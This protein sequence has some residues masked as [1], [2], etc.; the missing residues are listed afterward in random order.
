MKNFGRLFKTLLAVAMLFISGAAVYA[1]EPQGM[2]DSLNA[3]KI[4]ARRPFGS[5]IREVS[6]KKIRSVVSPLGTGDV[7]KFVQTLPGVSF[8]MEGTSA[9]YVRGG[10]N[11]NNLISL[12]GVT[13]YGTSHLMGLL[14]LIPDEIIAK[15]EFIVGGFD[16]WDG[17]LLSSHIK[18]TSHGIKDG[19]FG[20]IVVS[21]MNESLMFSLPAGKHFYFLGAA[22]V[23][24]AQYEY[25]VIAKDIISDKLN[26]P[27]KIKAQVYDYYGKASYIPYNR[28][29][30]NFSYLSSYD[31]YNWDTRDESSHDE[32]GWQNKIFIADA[33][34]TP[35]DKLNLYLSYSDN[36][37][38]S[39]QLQKRSVNEKNS[40]LMH[41]FSGISEK[42]TQV[43][44]SFEP[45][46]TI[47]IV[48]GAD[49]KKASFTPAAF[50]ARKRAPW[51]TDTLK[52][53]TSIYYA[54]AEIGNPDEACI[55]LA[56][57]FN[58][59][60]GHD[61]IT[62]KVPEF[63]VKGN[64]AVSEH[65]GIELT[66][67]RLA[68][69]YH[70]LEGVPTGFSIDLIV[71]SRDSL[72][73]EKADQFY[74]GIVSRGELPVNFSIGAF[75]KKMSGLVFF[76]KADKFFTTSAMEWE[77]NLLIGD[78][79]SRGLEVSLDGNYKKFSGRLAYTLSKT[80][81]TFDKLNEGKPFPF[82]FDR[83]HIL[84]LSGKYLIKDNERVTHALNGLFTYTSGHKESLRAG[85]YPVW[86]DPYD[87]F[88]W[89]GQN[90][91]LDYFT[92]PNN[93][94]MKPYIRLDISYSLTLKRKSVD[95]EFVLG[96]YN[97][98]NRHNPYALT[99]DM[100][101]ERWMKISIFPIM[102][103]ICYRMTF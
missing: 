24:P 50:A 91:D 34:W 71:P 81:R 7:I 45:S 35:I 63:R 96:I 92:H 64:L 22:R 18:M 52:A 5:S 15:N 67:D 10:N 102:P 33:D 19:G 2:V 40:T 89:K 94:T 17:N 20:S 93:Y 74:A 39:D 16:A 11:G 90:F 78:G 76:E 95:H 86:A 23:S 79:S 49:F 77:E 14:A 58:L 61:G 51:L 6:S 57:R 53:R 97:V 66:Y 37:F 68:Q 8:G 36:Y 69:F 28:L 29:T 4:T 100:E 98:F 12:D 38:H 1:Q 25:N 26:L 27:N 13:I 87:F 54:Q 3:S 43:R 80:D 62:K 32:M 44:I 30:F 56:S 9:F 31:A 85:T 21:N 84:S 46:E 60:K 48:A 59:Y 75:W 55:K 88:K 73:Y 82:K 42:K 83:R 65:L 103:S 101:S 47:K 41:M 72:S 99:W 70:T